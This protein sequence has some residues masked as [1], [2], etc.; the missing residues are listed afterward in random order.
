MSA[1]QTQFKQGCSSGG[2]SVVL[3]TTPTIS[4]FLFVTVNEQDK[5]GASNHTVN[6]GTGRN[7]TQI[8]GR[9]RARSDFGGCAFL[10][11]RQVVSGDSATI[12]TNDPDGGRLGMIAAEFSGIGSLFGAPAGSND[13]VGSTALAIALAPGGSDY[14]SIHG[15]ATRL[16][17]GGAFTPNSVTTQIGTIQI[18]GSSLGVC[19]SADAGIMTWGQGNATFGGTQSGTTKDSTYCWGGLGQAFTKIGRV[20]LIQIGVA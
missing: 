15:W 13:H 14:F 11:Y 1:V 18:T 10:Y 19:N 17:V 5:P 2:F 16:T 3:G 4:N 8:G 20:Q 7:F 6:C 12:T 9:I